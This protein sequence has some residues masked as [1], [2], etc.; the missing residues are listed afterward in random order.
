MKLK[1]EK[2]GRIRSADIDVRPLTVLIGPNNTNKTWTAYALYGLLQSFSRTLSAARFDVSPDEEDAADAKT[3]DRMRGVLKP[4]FEALNADPSPARVECS[5]S[6][7]SLFENTGQRYVHNLKAESL[8]LLL[9]LPHDQLPGASARLESLRTEFVTSLVSLEFVFERP[10]NRLQVK[11]N[12][13]WTLEGGK[14]EESSALFNYVDDAWTERKILALVHTQLWELIKH[15]VVFPAE[16]NGLLP[17]WPLLPASDDLEVPIPVADFGRFLGLAQAAAAAGRMSAPQAHLAALLKKAVGGEIAYVAEAGR[18]RLM[19]RTTNAEIPLQAAASLSRAV[20]GLSLYIERFFQ[21]DDVLIID[22]LEMNAHP[23]AQMALTELITS[24]VNAG[25]RVVLTTH[26]PYVVDHLNNLMEASRTPT[27]RREELA[28]K[29]ALGT[30]SSF[31]SPDKVAVHAVQEESPDGE[32]L[33]R[34][35]LNRKTGLIDWSTFSGV[36]EHVTNLYS[37]I[38]RAAEGDV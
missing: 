35:V 1:I 13:R 27:G 36:S 4:L 2:L 38:L 12:R 7:P 28:R 18:K 5:L 11:T 8:C 16:R 26:S 25:V 37:D 19:F 6:V 10:L 34:E 32:V 17:L 20:A 33:V 21:P 31:I 24:L 9:G 3:L 14:T 22:E 15:V 23:Q 30:A 29:F